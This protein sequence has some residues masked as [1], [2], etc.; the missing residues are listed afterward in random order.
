MNDKIEVLV[1][2]M[3]ALTFDLLH[4]SAF[5]LSAFV[6]LAFLPSVDI[7]TLIYSITTLHS[8]SVH[9]TKH[10]VPNHGKAASYCNQALLLGMTKFCMARHLLSP[11]KN[12][13]IIEKRS[14]RL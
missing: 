5:L 3:G 6:F 13:R 14:S 7:P 2:D 8:N 12:S 10:I 1:E 11:R 4:S 9:P